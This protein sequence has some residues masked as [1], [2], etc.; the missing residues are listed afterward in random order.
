MALHQI[1]DGWKSPAFK[2]VHTSKL[3]NIEG[4]SYLK[5]CG[6][7]HLL[8]MATESQYKFTCSCFSFMPAIHKH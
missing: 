2:P 3:V 1:S 8:L 6:L 7:V 5:I 4:V